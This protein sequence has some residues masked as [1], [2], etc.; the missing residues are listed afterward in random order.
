MR[1]Q[2]SQELKLRQFEHFRW[3]HGE[4]VSVQLQHQQ[5]AGDV[6][7]AARLQDTDL[8][9]TQ[10]SKRRKSRR[11]VKIVA[12]LRNLKTV[13]THIHIKNNNNNKTFTKNVS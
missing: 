2:H 3:Q 4:A 10:I 7:K 5:R 12:L 1:A 6:F 13:R 8:V 9:V 11:M